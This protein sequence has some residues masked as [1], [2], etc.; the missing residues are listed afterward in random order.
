MTYKNKKGFTLIETLVAIL[1]L[2]VSI[3]GPLTIASRGLGAALQSKNKTVALYLAQDAMEFVRHVRDSNRLAGSP[4][5]AGLDAC[6]SSDGGTTC[7]VDTIA[8][9]IHACG[10]GCPVLYY[11]NPL[12]IFNYSAP[13]DG[14]SDATRVRTM[15]TRTVSILTPVCNSG[16]TVCNDANTEAQVMV[17]VSWT[18][19]GGV[20]SKSRQM[21]IR[22]NMF[23]WQ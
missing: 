1:I 19:V 23:N 13:L 18:D 20:S 9:E 22:E 5:L 12:H 6:T 21:V 4:W 17:Q 7:T 8:S 10:F 2:S 11:N 3:A 16:G 15:F 14:G